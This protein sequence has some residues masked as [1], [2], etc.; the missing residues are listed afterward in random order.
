MARLS[1]QLLGGF[2]ATLDG[3]PVTAFESDKVRA[4]LAYLA[5]EPE[6]AHRREKLVG[7]LWPERPEAVGRQN[8]RQALSNLRRAL[9]DRQARLP[10]LVTTRHTLQFNRASD[11]CVDVVAFRELLDAC[12]NHRHETQA[13]CD[14]CLERLEKALALCG[15][16]FL[17]G[18]SL[19]DSAAFDDWSLLERERLRR[20]E[21]EARRRV[22]DC[23]VRRGAYDRCAEQIRRWVELEPWDEEAHR[24]LMH[25]L[26]QGGRRS[27]ALHRYAECQ[28]ILQVDLG[29][30]P[31]VETTALYER[32]R[33]AAPEAAAVAG[34]APRPR[35]NLPAQPIP[36]VGRERELIEIGERLEDPDCRLLTLVGPGGAG[37]TRLALEAAAA[38]LDHFADGAYFVTLAQLQSAEAIVPT[39]AHAIGLSF[40][41]GGDPGD[42]LLSYLGSK[43]MLLILDNFEHLLAYDRQDEEDGSSLVARIVGAAPRITL[44]V[45]SRAALKLQ[46]EHLYHICGMLYP[47]LRTGE[48]AAGATQDVLRYSAVQL[49][50]QRARQVQ[51]DFALSA[52]N[53]TDVIRICA[54]VSG[55]PLGILLASSWVRMLPPGEIVA[56][57]ETGLDLLET[58]LGDVPERQRSMRAVFDHSWDLLSVRERQV[59]QPLSVL[60]GGFTREAAL[61]VA[62]ASL[63]EL[64]SLVA[65]SLVQPADRAR[66]QVHELLRQYAEEKL[67]E[68]P[69]ASQA[70]RDRHA[71]Y[72]SAALEAWGSDLKG[73]RQREALL[74][75]DLEIGN[76]RA[77][78]DWAVRQG[79][80]KLLRRAGEGL[81]L[82]YLRR[83]LSHEAVA[84]FHRAAS[85]LR[86]T[87][88]S[89]DAVSASAA[90][91]LITVLRWH[92]AAELRLYHGAVAQHVAEEALDILRGPHLIREDTRALEAG[93]LVALGDAQRS[94]GQGDSKVS[95]TR[96]LALAQAVGD[97]WLAA[98]ALVRLGSAVAD[99]G[100][101]PEAWGQLEESL[102]LFRAVGDERGIAQ[103]TGALAFV[104]MSAGEVEAA[105]RR[106]REALSAMRSLG[107]PHGAANALDAVAFALLLQ[108]KNAEGQNLFEERLAII[109]DLGLSPVG[110]LTGLGWA[111]MQ[112]GQYEGAREDLESGLQIASGEGAHSMAA[113]YASLLGRLAVR[114]SAYADARRLCSR[115]IVGFDACESTENA[116]WARGSLGLAEIALG[117]IDNARRCAVEGLTWARDQASLFVL[118]DVLPLVAQIFLA[119]GETE[120]AVEIYA[121]ACM[122][123]AVANSQWCEDVVG[124]PIA[125]AAASLPLEAAAAA[126]LRGRARDMHATIVELIDEFSA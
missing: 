29:A 37:K 72:Y 62:G 87:G 122:L 90:L 114:D 27:A 123:P 125:H 11:H 86:A 50:V 63:L 108:G 30:E 111:R 13:L 45:T 126:Q 80:R 43:R 46:Q 118:C 84:A 79:D 54:L 65:R 92:A 107:D 35:H 1:I 56:Q 41:G 8:L 73:P 32:I 39:I 5:V 42:Q 57:L 6:R 66:F 112:Q 31:S 71:V 78:W 47:D 61:A 59:M 4:L 77:A 17:D 34:V 106:G 60:R 23:H 91:D 74:E 58:D 24:R 22:A 97:K 67:A 109:K 98:M 68:V 36:L 76:V 95:F 55:M 113:A 49:F 18:F 120:R 44:L 121:L 75:M 25:A 101:W 2:Q 116:F 48:L 20:L 14:R 117:E 69:G 82:Y 88:A 33:G 100:D 104:L 12:A 110:C 10:F 15:R 85:R 21:I 99:S 40:H 103:V 26:W 3:E 70:A 93:L 89:G 16:P 52:R 51:R 124:K 9:G 119:E 105:E 96:G 7:L 102:T 28:R 64:R 53:V 115:S 19:A 81:W 38:Q 94:T 83:G